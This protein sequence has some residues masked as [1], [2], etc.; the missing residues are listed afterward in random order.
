MKDSI[1]AEISTKQLKRNVHDFKK[2]RSR[3]WKYDDKID[4]G[5]LKKIYW[6][7]NGR[8]EAEKRKVIAEKGPM[9]DADT[10]VMMILVFLWMK[11]MMAF[12]SQAN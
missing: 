10:K 12:H 1:G 4:F 8:N 9:N 7:N 6:G 5:L 11:V 3:K 2:F